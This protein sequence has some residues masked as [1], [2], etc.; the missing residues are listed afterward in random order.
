M[1]KQ[2]IQN[3]FAKHN[4][5]ILKYQTDNIFNIYENHSKNK[6]V[7]VLAASP[8]AGKTLMTICYVDLY[9]K[10]NPKAKVLILTHGT[11]ILRSQF[12][13]EI[14]KI[15]PEQ[16][17]FTWSEITPTEKN[18]NSQVIISLPHTIKGISKLPKFDLLIVDEAHHYYLAKNGIVKK[19]IEK[20]KPKHQLLLTGTPS[21]FINDTKVY[22]INPVTINELL[23]YGMITDVL[24][25]LASSKYDFRITNYNNDGELK[26]DAKIKDDDT[27]ATMD[28]LLK[29]IIKR[30]KSV[31]KLNP[32]LYSTVKN[33]IGWTDALRSLEKT[34][35]ACKSKEQAVQVEKYLINK[36]IDTAL[37]I[38]GDIDLGVKDDDSKQIERFKNEKNCL[39]LV[40]VNRGV[41]GFNLPELENVIDMTCSHNI[42]VIFQLLGRVLR[43]H[44][45]GKQKLF[46]KVVPHNLS[47]WF[48][49]VMTACLLLTDREYYLKYNGKNF[50][51]MN[52]L[53]KKA[54]PNRKDNTEEGTDT[55]P[56]GGKKPA[57]KKVEYEGVPAIELF[58]E[59]THKN[60]AILN[61]YEWVTM[62]EVKGRIFDYKNTIL[63]KEEFVRRA[64]EIHF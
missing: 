10:E 30:L 29:Q 12:R 35:I 13:D 54:K 57:F 26:K 27:K 23:S 28:N 18:L 4:K 9:L 58:N 16:K 43:K 24:V 21:K 19:I 42:D 20:V 33:N 2:D 44:P 55:K 61:G 47:D 45:T 7:Q 39:V 60:K 38:S 1:I 63:T 6:L 49:H 50:L 5:N 52:I 40:V 56:T 32:I 37:S 3:W 34:M 8:S 51:D 25:E 14:E 48:D 11:T 62:R 31:A 64:R 36:G 17:D 15:N 59:L 46:F 22:T 53:V 41:L